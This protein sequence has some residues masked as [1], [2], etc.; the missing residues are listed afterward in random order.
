MK[1]IRKPAIAAIVA[2]VAV[3]SLAGC[4]AGAST[5]SSSANYVDGKAFTLALSADPG[6]LDPQAS[7]V[8]ALFALTHFAYDP[9]VNV[10]AK[11][12]ITSG[13]AKAW[14][15]DGTTATFTMKKGVT[16]S[17]G[18]TF[19]PKT[20]AANVTWVED[21]ANKSPFL[22]AFIPAGITAASDDSAGT[23]TLTLSSPAPFLLQ[24]IANLP[25]VCDAGLADRSKLA[26]ATIGTGPYVLTEAVA[27]DH[28]TYKVNKKY[29]WGPGGAST[30][31][32]GTPTTVTAKVIPNE[33]T[34]ANLLLSGQVNS[35]EIIGPDA[36]RLSAAKLFTQNTPALIGEQWYNNTGSHPTTDPAVRM[37]LTQ[38]LDL[39]QLQKVLTSGKGT[40]ATSFAVVPPVACTV[41]SV[42]KALPKKDIAAAKA[43]LDAAGWVVG[44]DGIRAKNG[45]KLD[46]TFLYDS[47]LGTGGVAASELATKA[48]EA[49]GAKVTA[50]QQDATA[51]SGALFGTGAWDIAWEPLNVNSPDQLVGF[52]SGPAAPKGTNFANVQNADYSSNVAKA[53]TMNGTEGCQTWADAETALVKAA[54]VVPFAN[55]V[56]KTFGKGAVFQQIGEIVPTSI[57]MLG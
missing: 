12:K 53:M 21:P 45:V 52:L 33:T 25:M 35:A 26:T 40:A 34:A 24:S 16:C 7:A 54:D 29:T 11:G 50:T 6:N 17:D 2:A 18:S 41:D 39:P 14:K 4:A 51:I 48:W 13:L 37:A 15:L 20:A 27:N 57:R 55:N 46:L 8:S 36:A 10:D 28:Y 22:G 32:K 1:S 3:S 47:T 19:T 30:S 31:A 56:V 44:S 23:V 38:A 42:S 5:G 49:I 9:L 43:A